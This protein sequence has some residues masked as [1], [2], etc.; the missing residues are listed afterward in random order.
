[1]MFFSI[2]HIDASEDDSVVTFDDDDDED[3]DDEDALDC[4]GEMNFAA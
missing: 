3:N 4:E 2:T 1:M